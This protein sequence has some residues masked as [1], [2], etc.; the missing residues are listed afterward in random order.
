MERV[1][2]ARIEFVEESDLHRW[3]V[4]NDMK[5]YDMAE[6][7]PCDRYVLWKVKKGMPISRVTAKRIREFTR[8]EVIPVENKRGRINKQ[9]DP[10]PERKIVPPKRNIMITLPM[11]HYEK[12]CELCG[13]R[14]DQIGKK[15]AISTLLQNICK[16]FLRTGQEIPDDY[17]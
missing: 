2:M 14:S 9:K 1:T 12:L 11:E 8:D 15:F 13:K 16:H 3:L 10:E 4:R 6:K 17:K 5:L 7:I